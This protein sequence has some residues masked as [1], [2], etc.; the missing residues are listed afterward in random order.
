MMPVHEHRPEIQLFNPVI[1]L[2]LLMDNT[3]EAITRFLKRKG[4][5]VTTTRMTVLRIMLSQHGPVTL[6]DIN[7]LSKKKLDRVSVYRTLQLFLKKEIIL[8]A[9]NGNGWPHYIVNERPLTE[10]E[11]E[12]ATV[13]CWFICN[14]CEKV[15]PVRIYKPLPD[16]AP[17]G[18]LVTHC[19]LILKGSCADCARS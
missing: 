3:D 2:M 18:H 10:R 4:A 7:K 12:P 15:K 17:A 13:S 14:T 1:L 16:M 9:R 8:L 6:A 19:Q 11:L 5:Y